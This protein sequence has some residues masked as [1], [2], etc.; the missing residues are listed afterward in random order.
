MI[1]SKRARDAFDVSQESVA[2][3]EQ[4]TEDPFSQ[5]CLLA[6]RLI[7]AGVRFV[8]LSLGGWDT[9]QDN[10]SKLRE[11]L[12]PKLDAGLSSLFAGLQAKGLLE[13]TTVMATGEFGRTP[14]INDRSAEGGRDH[15]PRCMFMIMG[16]GVVRG[17]QVIGASDATGAGPAQEAIH[18]EDVAA[19]F[20]QALGIDPH[21]EYQT[22]TGRPVMLVRD[23]KVIPDLFV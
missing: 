3:R 11:N 2:F 6:V 4:F 19:S 14:R 10:F 23:G 20:Y 12:L 17:G 16:G 8:T 21:Q 15:Y 1:S 5:S 7:E 9:H 18:P 13:S 22:P